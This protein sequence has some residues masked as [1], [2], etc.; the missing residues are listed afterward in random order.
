MTKS[1][2]TAPEAAKAV[3]QQTGDAQEKARPRVKK[4]RRNRSKK[5]KPEDIPGLIAAIDAGVLDQRL[6]AARDM[7]ALRDNLATQPQPVVEALIR[8]ALAIDGVIMARLATELVKPGN[9]LLDAN[10]ELHPLVVKYWP[11]VRN[12][13]LKS[14]KALLSIE[15]KGTPPSDSGDITSIILEAQHGGGDAA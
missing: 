9:S 1:T 2:K 11:E 12:G 15:D 14:G 6:S 8:D 10:G 4:E 7:L 13:I 5:R 3:R